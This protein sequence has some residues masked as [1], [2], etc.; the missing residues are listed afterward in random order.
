MVAGFEKVYEIGRVFR[1]DVPMKDDFVADEYK[2]HG[3]FGPEVVPEGY[4]FVMGDHRNNS[5]DSRVFSFVPRKY[6]LGKVQV[7]WWPPARAKLLA[8]RNVSDKVSTSVAPFFWYNVDTASKI[9][10]CF[11]R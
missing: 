2:D 3:S 7:R 6:I 9:T 5:S 8:L 11:S 10:R 1:N 4:Y